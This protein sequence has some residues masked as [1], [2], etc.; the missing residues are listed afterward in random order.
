MKVFMLL[1]LITLMN[2]FALESFS[3]KNMVSLKEQEQTLKELI[4]TI[5]EQTDYV[6]LYNNQ[7]IDVD[8]KVT[9]RI[10]SGRIETILK[11]SLLNTGIDHNIV[12][13]QVVLYPLKRST[14]TNSQQE[15]VKIN[16]TVTEENGM[17]LPGVSVVIMGTTM[18]ITTDFDGNYTIDTETGSVLVFSFVGYV[19]KEVKVTGASTE[20]NVVLQE[21]VQAI[22][23]VVVT[24]LGIAREK[25]GLGYAVQT[26]KGEDLNEARESNFVNSLAGKVAGVNITTSGAVGGSSRVTIRG[27]GSLNFGA[28][29]PLYIVDGIPVGNAGTS[30]QTS[31]DYGNSSA[32]INP[33]DV[34]S[35]TVLKGPAAAA[36]YGSRAANGA[37]VI[38]TKS[39]KDSKGLGVS[40]TTGTTMEEILRLPK[41]Q[42]EFGQGKE[43]D[44]EG[45]N[46]GASWSDYPDGIRDGYDESWGPRLNVGN[47]ERQ[48]HSPTLG[49]M[50]G[51][52]VMNPN[53]GEVIPTPWV[54]Y[55]NNIKDFF[56]T[57][58][59]YFNNVAIT[60]AN[61]KG[62]FRFSY[63]NMDQ[64]GV[65]PN[66]DL[67]RNTFALKGD[68][69]LTDKFRINAAMNYVNTTSTNRP[70]TGYGRHSLMYFMVWSV[71]NMDINSMRNYWQDG[72][73]GKEQFKYNYGENHNNPFFY[74]YEN[75]KGQDKHRLFGNVSL[76]YDITDKLSFMAR[77]GT[78]VYNDFRPQQWAV[79]TVG[80]EQGRYQEIK[81]FFE[82]RNY[83]FLLSYKDKLG[84]DFN[85]KVST[86]G[87]QMLRETR[88]GSSQAPQ[89]L[90]PGIYTV[91]NTAAEI[92]ARSNSTKMKVNS[93]YAFA[94]L[95]YKSTY[96]MDITARNDWSSTLPSDNNSFFY[97]SVSFSTIIDQ[98]IAMPDWVTQAK[99]RFGVAQ[100]G[101]GTGAY[102]LYNTFG[103]AGSW[104]SNYSL[105]S[106][107]DLKNN[108]LKPESITTYEVGGDIRLF[109]NKIGLDFTFYDTRSKD[110]II[111]IPLTSSTSYNSRTINAGEIQNKGFELMLNATPVQSASGF[112]WDVM[113]NFSTN[114]S[115]I[116]ELAP[117]IGSIT[118]SAEGEDASIQAR[119]GESMGALYGPGYQRVESGPMKGEII[120]FDN[121]RPKPTDDDIYLG[122]FNPDWISGISNEFS[123]KN[124]SLNVLF[125][126]HYGGK[127]ISRFYNK[128]MGAGQLLESAG[129]RE[130]REVGH[131]YDDPYYVDGAALVDGAYVPNNISTDG[132]FSEGV[133]GIDARY[134]HKGLLDHITEGQMFDATYVKLRELKLGYKFSDRLFGDVLK[135][136][137]IS[138]VGRNLFLWTP[139][140]NQH[141]DPE[142]SAATTGGGLVPGFENMS[143]P[144]TRSYG[145][146]LSLKF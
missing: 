28:N 102:N 91:T 138:L 92:Q 67:Q 104:G 119:V 122:N 125:D 100:V 56:E 65:V 131:E 52:D 115:K 7:L 49:G 4:S 31:A 114:D 106:G 55:P 117:G 59:T 137:Y 93:L 126:I 60:G 70:E 66:N 88:F 18:G 98:I 123:Y 71:R 9:N 1:F 140:S 36:L 145:I 103:F 2:A 143:L 57:G 121:G 134:F 141:F 78:D 64:T 94:Q 95:D 139:E 120:I 14:N 110:Q 37:I 54:A 33:A 74:Q 69:Q 135:D 113:V 25:K 44:Y 142:V 129:G 61:D 63:T 108:N 90:I 68:Y 146:N 96:Y 72:Y 84:D 53:R 10:K 43:G 130:A 40:V 80:S 38:T 35:M 85:Y 24:A 13:N 17:P 12:N 109:N 62:S 128:G 51:G 27:E 105:A 47:L 21:D 99:L 132:T 116:L 30:N 46:F 26:V 3:Q 6:F 77:G 79:S 87:N 32:E 15:K 97:P 86:G 50:R 22:D 76:F 19:S 41:F 133:N 5:Q 58:H 83:D 73:E 144:S 75:T 48:F 20:L 111:G 112:K 101:N 107:A 34:E 82:E 127:F 42:N 81:L 8:T 124:V 16:G 118:Q 136:V 89:L 23:E 39:G 29:A 11:G 45:S